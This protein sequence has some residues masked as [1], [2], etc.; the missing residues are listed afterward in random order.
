MDGRIVLYNRT[1]RKRLHCV[2]ATS[3]SQTTVSSN[4]NIC[5]MLQEGIQPFCEFG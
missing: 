1:A 4:T 2:G 3:D 5:K